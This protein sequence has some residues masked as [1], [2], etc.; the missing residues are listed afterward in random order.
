MVE[1]SIQ[2]AMCDTIQAAKHYVYIE[3][4]F[5]I[6]TTVPGWEDKGI[7]SPQV[8]NRVGEALL[9]RILRAYK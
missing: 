3:N 8:L 1:E 9:N 7:N 6:T 5:F 4:Q 2:Q